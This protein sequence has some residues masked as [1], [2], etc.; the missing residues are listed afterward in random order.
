MNRKKLLFTLGFI[1]QITLSFN[2]MFANPTN[3]GT[4]ITPYSANAEDG[5]APHANVTGYQYMELNGVLY[6]RLWSYTYARWEEPYWTK[7]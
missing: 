7:A 5:I 2:I 3:L 1:A 6:K 4:G